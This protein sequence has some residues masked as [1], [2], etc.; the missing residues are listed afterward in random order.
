[1]N[2]ESN[3]PGRW[4]YA[5]SAPV[6]GPGSQGYQIFR[7][8]TS[9]D[10]HAIGDLYVTEAHPWRDFAAWLQKNPPP[11]LLYLSEDA[12]NAIVKKFN[13]MENPSWEELLKK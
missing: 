4:I 6:R 9:E 10:L 11:C 5:L 1:M 12:A 2:K 7:S 8:F 13:E 3:K